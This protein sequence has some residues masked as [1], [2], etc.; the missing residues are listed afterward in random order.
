MT[1]SVEGLELAIEDF[2]T[3]FLAQKQRLRSPRDF[4]SLHCTR[5]G[6]AQHT[7]NS[8]PNPKRP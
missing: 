8:P 6:D 4:G 3:M 2:N 7:R 1:P 5:I